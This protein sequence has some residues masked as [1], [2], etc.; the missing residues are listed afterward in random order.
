M[1]RRKDPSKQVARRSHRG[2]HRCRL[3]KIR[4]DEAKPHC[5]PCTSRGYPDCVYAQILKWETD[6][7]GRAF[8]RAGV[9]SKSRASGANNNN[10]NATSMPTTTLNNYWSVPTHVYSF[11]FLNTFISDFAKGES[12]SS[13]NDDV[14][15][16]DQKSAALTLRRDLNSM[17]RPV[18]YIQLSNQAESQLLSYYLNR[19][20]PMTIPSATGQS[21]FSALIFPFAVSSASPTLMNALLGLAASHRARTDNRYQPVALS[22]SAKVIRSLRLTLENKSSV[23]IAANSEILVLMMLLCQLEII[24]E[25]DKRWVTHL[26]G[27]RDLIRFRRQTVDSDV[28]KTEVRQQNP[29]ERIIRFTERY[30]AFYDVMGRTACGEEPIFGNDFWS[31]QE[32]QLDLWMGCSPHLVSIISEITELSFQY[33]RLSA[34]MAE[35]CWQ[36][37][38]R[39]RMRLV[40]RLRQPQLKSESDDENIRHTV[41]LKRLTVELYLHSALND[42]TPTTPV[43]RQSVRGILRLVAKLLAAGVKAG[44]TWPL[45]MAACQLEPTEELEW[46]TDELDDNKTPRYARP[47][48]LYALDKLSDSLANVARTRSVIEKVWKQREAAS[49]LSSEC[50]LSSS[51]N[52]FND[53]AR[54]VAPLCHNISLA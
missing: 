11:G 49:F 37:L 32:D 27:A 48:I 6:Y 8:G 51:T 38:E 17:N 36:D 7:V 46:A 26:R 20:C 14:S 50:Q 16:D 44:L 12:S 25:C 35:G 34:S 4:C 24:A 13:S 2:C 52:A 54:F 41:E 33:N 29:W 31:A 23:D 45:F 28:A 39:Q 42:S 40:S 15:C 10:K 53:W 3:H 30:F 43:V 1:P 5:G 21:P 9:W 18:T 47:L 19:I 22:Y